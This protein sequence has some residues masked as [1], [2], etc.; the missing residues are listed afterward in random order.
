MTAWRK[1][2]TLREV[3]EGEPFSAKLDGTPI[4]IFRI[5]E[6][7]HAVHDVCSH[8]YA[9]LSQGYQDGE[10][11]ECPLHAAKFNVVTGKCLSGPGNQDIAVFRVKIE[12]DDVLVAPAEGVT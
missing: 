12:G 6:A 1:V 11:I 8:E 10:T 7:C 9:L 3:A 4:G 2:C 5:G